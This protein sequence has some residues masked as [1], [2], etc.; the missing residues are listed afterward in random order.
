MKLVVALFL[1]LAANVS[2][3][4]SARGARSALSSS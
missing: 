4:P 2:P 1:A 3:M